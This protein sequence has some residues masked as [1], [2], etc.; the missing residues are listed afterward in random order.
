MGGGGY[1][2]WEYIIRGLRESDLGEDLVSASTLPT[3]ISF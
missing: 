3:K 2:I 1:M